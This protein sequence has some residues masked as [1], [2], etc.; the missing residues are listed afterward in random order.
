MM[1][2]GNYGANLLEYDEC[3]TFLSTDYGLNW[4]MVR[5][6]AHKYEFGDMGT[7][8]VLIDDEKETDHV[9]WSKNRGDTW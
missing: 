9:W 1:G 2:V 7:L 8:L 4:K 6:G 3:N 5:E